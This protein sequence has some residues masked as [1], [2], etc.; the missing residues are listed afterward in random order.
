MRQDVWISPIVI[1]LAVCAAMAAIIAGI[2]AAF[3]AAAV[4]KRK[5]DTGALSARLTDLAEESSRQIQS[6]AR[7]SAIIAS[8]LQRDQLLSQIILVL[9]DYLPGCAVRLLVYRKDGS[10]ERIGSNLAHSN[11]RE[12][13]EESPIPKPSDDN[14]LNLIATPSGGRRNPEWELFL[15]DGAC[16][17]FAYNFPFIAEEEFKGS[18]VVTAEE[19]LGERVRLFLGDIATLIA[20]AHQNALTSNQKDIINEQFGKSVDPKVRDHLLSAKEAGSILDVSVLFLDVRNFTARSERLGPVDTVAFLNG[21]FDSCDAVVRE[22][23]GFINKFTGDGFMAVFGAPEKNDTH[24]EDAVRAALRILEK[25]GDIDVGIG[26]ASGQAL[27]G[28]IGS[29]RRMEYTVIGDTVN[30]ASRVESLCKL[31]GA[32]IMVTGE[33]FSRLVNV[34][35]ESRFLG[36]VQ[37]KGK[38]KAIAIHEIRARGREEGQQRELARGMSKCW[39]EGFDRAVAAYYRAEF[40]EAESAFA[41]LAKKWPGDKAIGWYHLRCAERQAEAAREWDGVERMTAK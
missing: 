14:L 17:D 24:P 33:T 20:S 2:L 29:A 35:T 3:L 40:A 9:C 22:E 36:T 5:N 11:F 10:L 37:L 32:E 25:I 18:L 26:I 19:P 6:F 27:A 13:K 7:I 38:N 41:S 8:S 28:T 30:T 16:R 34:K 39:D 4:R 31:F 23:G 21:L 1:A 12:S 15:D